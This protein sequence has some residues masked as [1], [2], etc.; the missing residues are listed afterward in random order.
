MVRIHR[1]PEE[2]RSEG[3]WL[4]CSKGGCDVCPKFSDALRFFFWHCGISPKIAFLRLRR[5]WR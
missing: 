4:V 5:I 3:K 2:M 1:A